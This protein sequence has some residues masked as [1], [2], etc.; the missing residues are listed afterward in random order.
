MLDFSDG[1]LILQPPITIHQPP[2][3]GDFFMKRTRKT[4]NDEP[5]VLVDIDEFCSH[6]DLEIISQG[7][8]DKIKISTVNISRPG[9]QLAGFF[10]H[11][12]SERVQIFGEQEFAYLNTLPKY[13][14]KRAIESLFKHDFPCLILTSKL[15]AHEEVIES[16]E[17][18]K[19][20][21][22]RAKQRSTLLMGSLSSYLGT[23]LAPSITIHGVLVE[24]YGVGMLI[25]GDSSVGK[26]ETALELIQRNHRLIADDA[27]TIS[28]ISESLIGTSPPNIRHFM[29]VRGFGIINVSSMYGAGSVK[30]NQVVDIVIKLEEWDS[31][32]KYNRL[33]DSKESYEILGLKIPLYTVPVK[34][35]RNLAAVLEVGARNFRLQSMGYNVLEELDRRIFNKE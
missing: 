35:G 17:K 34:P 9:L 33:G 2:K 13:E 27:V 1:H 8:K 11:F 23:V 15:D 25:I 10:E 4:I 16:A 14:R 12:S 22:L 18:F 5:F 30:L 28:R 21:V 24:L 19:R 31:S 29:E 3:I 6:L 32:K 20:V 26:S 7:D